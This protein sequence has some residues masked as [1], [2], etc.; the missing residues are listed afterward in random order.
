MKIERRGVRGFT[1]IELLVVIAIIAILA[2]LLLP[3]LGKAKQQAWAT[4]CLN[5]LKQIGIATILYADDNADA[6]PRSQHTGQSWV[7]TL[8]PYTAG[9]N[10][11]RCARDPHKTRLYSYALNDFLLPP[12]AND[13]TARNYSKAASVPAPTETFF[14]A[15]CA[16]G[17]ASSDHFH[18]ADPED[19]DYSPDGFVKQIAVKRHL[20][21][22]NYLFVDGH[23]ERANWNLVKP[24][25][26]QTG[27]R[28][29]NPAGKP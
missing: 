27:S 21:T 3:A 16:D 26:T 1:L 15:E 19:G 10:L 24:K 2:A 25:L 11:W 5:N 18:F 22:A 20:N 23:V 14:M 7:A 29:V 17:Y 8:Q 28:F 6:L 13:A 4:S 9:T 12:D